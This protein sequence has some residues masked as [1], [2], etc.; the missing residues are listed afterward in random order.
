V[1]AA[2]GRRRPV[3]APVAASADPKATE[4]DDG[5]TALVR[6]AT[7]GRKGALC[8]PV[9]D[10]VAQLCPSIRVSQGHST[11]PRWTIWCQAAGFPCRSTAVSRLMRA[12]LTVVPRETSRFG[13][14]IPS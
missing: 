10:G 9:A 12:M 13:G 4:E 7:G 1:A 2:V 14:G 11:S 3:A 5:R 6:A 8:A